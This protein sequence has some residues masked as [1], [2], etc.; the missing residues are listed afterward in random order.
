MLHDD[1]DVRLVLEGFLDRDEE[2]LMSDVLDSVALQQ[3]ELLDF[4]LLDDL[5][6]VS[7]VR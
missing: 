5:H 2:I 6:R 4:V 3:V 1:V 7:F